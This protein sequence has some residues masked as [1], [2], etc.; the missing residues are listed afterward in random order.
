MYSEY[1]QRK[2]VIETTT[3]LQEQLKA[4]REQIFEDFLATARSS[5]QVQELQDA[6]KQAHEALYDEHVSKRLL[7]EEASAL[8]A[9][10]AAAEAASTA[11]SGHDAAEL[12]DLVQHLATQHEA[13]QQQ[14]DE[15]QQMLDDERQAAEQLYLEHECLIDLY[16]TAADEKAA[17]KAELRK[18]LAAQRTAG[19]LASPGPA[20]GAPE[21]QVPSDD[22]EAAEGSSEDAA[23]E[24]VV[25]EMGSVTV[26][27][28]SPLAAT[29][30]KQHLAD[31]RS[32][33]DLMLI[34]DEE[35]VSQA[36]QV[37]EA[38]ASLEQQL[39]QPPA[40]ASM[41]GVSSP[42]AGLSSGGSSAA[43]VQEAAGIAASPHPAE[44]LALLAE[45]QEA[46]SFV[47]ELAADQQEVQQRV[48]QVQASVSSLMLDAQEDGAHSGE[49]RADGC[50]Q[51]C[52][53]AC[54]A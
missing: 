48:L 18:Q 22:E 45:L 15:V 19:D 37:Q 7:Q 43:A 25:T 41:A 46:A 14:L 44:K 23:A 54:T 50:C 52:H 10:L 42:A 39:L 16:T 28:Y 36:A 27:D 17:L 4:A 31:I 3:E 49:S 34:K 40:P 51:R 12:R 38:L 2:G 53:A 26:V 20:D 32:S 5:R 9:K 8:K 24:P 1:L 21:Q 29:P 13:T 11:S 47:K 35:V 33:C 30:A 6:L